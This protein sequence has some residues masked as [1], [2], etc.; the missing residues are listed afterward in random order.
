MTYPRIRLL[1]LAPAALLALLGAAA[2]GS[3]SN[4]TPTTPHST[5]ATSTRPLAGSP[6]GATSKAA[7]RITIKN[8]A[9]T[10]S[11]PAAAGSTV[12]VTNRDSTAHTVTAD[13][14]GAFDV[15]VQPGKT[16]TFTAPT[17]PGTYKFH[18]TFHANM[19]GTLTVVTH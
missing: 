3:S 16:G 8:F 5:G 12:Q 10:V 15:T 9:Y 2:C 7:V 4:S 17:K 19:H 11:G 18:C 6:S 13:T 14:G 1:L